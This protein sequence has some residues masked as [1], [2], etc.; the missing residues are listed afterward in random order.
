[1]SDF[2]LTT[3][4]ITSLVSAYTTTQDQLLI[5]PYTAKQTKYK[6]MIS[7]YDSIFTNMTSFQSVLSNMKAT[8][9][10][11]VFGNKTVLSTDSSVSGT[12]TIAA[13][14]GSYQLQTTQ[15]AKTDN[16][17]SGI[18]SNSASSSLSGIHNFVIN[19]GDGTN[20]DFSSNVQVTFGS[21]ET[22]QSA[23]QKIRDAINSD[24]AVVQSVQKS[25]T[26][27][28]TG[29][30]ASININLNGTNQVISVN[31]GGTYN[32][33]IDEMV[34]NVNANISGVTAAKVTDSTT[35]NV[36]LKLTVNDNSNYISVSNESGT[37]I[38]SDLGIAAVKEKSAAGLLTASTINST[39]SDTQFT[40]TSK[41]SGLDFRIKNL[42]DSSG[43]NAL[44]SF[45]LNLGT[46]RPTFDQTG[47]SVKGGFVYS[48]ISASNNQLNSKF[49]FNGIN[50]Q[51][52]SNAVNDLITGVTINLNSVSAAGSS[53]SV[54]TVSQDANST[55]TQINSFIS[56]FN[57]LYTL[58]KTNSSYG[59]GTLYSDSNVSSI[60]NSLSSSAISALPGSNPSMINTLSKIGIS[61]SSTTG[62]SITDNS[63][64]QNSLKNNS[65][66]VEA[67]FNST[68]GIANT[69][70]NKLNPYLGTSGFIKNNEKS[71]NANMTYVTD[72]ITA[73]QASITKSA[74][75]LTTRYQELQA[76]LAALQTTQSFFNSLLSASTSTTG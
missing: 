42:S 22:N 60:I 36:S 31:G 27:S 19:T 26:D 53:P 52:N 50:V 54:L 33:L 3:T 58:L 46:D 75:S 25:A 61:F 41:N 49:F 64:F 5:D 63:L 35:G 39:S 30:P 4:Q 74:A 17:V 9:S 69:L 47:S 32:D 8:G 76:Q 73:N 28:Y 72:R 34:K 57:S 62:L 59:S 68:N 65:S 23:L 43:S 6:N 29:G 13:A 11:S 7:S 37:D 38:V 14:T 1:M 12:A 10:D 51:R 15:L 2:S 21:S 18:F 40:L 16:L 44:D 24:Q 70:Y 71:I 66:G 20:N 56:G 48:D 45:G 55:S 67:L